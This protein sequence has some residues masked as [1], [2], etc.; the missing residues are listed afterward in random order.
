M[1]AR[2]MSK[3]ACAI[4]QARMGSSRFPGKMLADLAGQ[5]VLWHIIHRLRRCVTL[6]G[7]ILATSDGAADDPL[8]AAAED[9]G[10]LVVRGPE[11]NVLRRF[12]LALEHT[13]APV[14][15]RICGDSVLIDPGL[16][17][18]LVRLLES[19]H[20]DYPRLTTPSSDCGI[21]AVSRRVLERI[22]AEKAGHPVAVEHVTGY[23]GTDP[24]FGTA[25]PLALPDQD[26]WVAG[27]RFSIDTPADLEFMRTL[28][29]RLGAAAGEIDFLAAVA[30]IKAEPGLLDINGHVRQRRADETAPAVVIR[31]DA[32]LSHGLGHLVRCLAIAAALRDRCS[33]AVTFALGGDPALATMVREEAFP[34]TLLPGRNRAGELAAVLADTGAAALLMDV[35]TPCDAAELAAIRAAGCR[36]AVLD[37]GSE[38]RLAADLGFYPPAGDALDWQGARGRFFAGWDWLALRQQFSPPPPWQPATPPVALILAGGSDPHGLR[39]RLLGIAAAALPETWRLTLVL[40]RATSADSG[41]DALAVTLGDRLTL[42]RDVTEMAAL[43]AGSSLAISVFGGTAY[44]LAAV[45]VPAILL[46]LDADHARSAAALA[47][48]GAALFAGIAAETAADALAAAISALAADPERR[49]Q[50]SAAARALI[51][52]RGSQRIAASLLG[53]DSN[54]E[55]DH[56]SPESAGFESSQNSR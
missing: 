35:R 45:G 33:A 5:P 47:T 20:G 50:I 25:V 17:D 44:E 22:I 4:I 52:G 30:L 1:S 26:R 43:M 24:G 28:H 15:L 16:T 10:V 32:G 56:P 31:C 38:R 42:R 37:D 55:Q 18:T 36:F 46:G 27:A 48:A 19:S 13:R 39:T 40:G 12:A 34:V 11:Q 41:L 23:L 8:A 2:A 7:I 9:F 29:R 14:I 6:D 53:A 49:K 51:D 21:D 54:G 3:S